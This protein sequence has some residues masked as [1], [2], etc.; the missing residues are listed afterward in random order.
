MVV[1]RHFISIMD[2]L[3]LSAS[4]AGIAGFAETIV[5]KTYKYIKDAKNADKSIARFFA[6]VQALLWVLEGIKH[7][8]KLMSDDNLR[9]EPSVRGHIKN[10]LQLV[11]EVKDGLGDPEVAK[12][13]P[14]KKIWRHL[15]W[16]FDKDE[17]E[18]L[19][20]RLERQKTALSLAFSTQKW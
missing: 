20:K 18:D 1:P 4:I 9:I 11:K 16:P 8:L 14:F 13:S 10:C 3:S 5:S 6:E 2:P 12:Q 19:V 17:T 15:K 7:T